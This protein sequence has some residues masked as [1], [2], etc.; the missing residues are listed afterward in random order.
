MHF[1]LAAASYNMFFKDCWEL[2]SDTELSFSS[3]VGGL[4]GNTG[5]AGRH[6]GLL[7]VPNPAVHERM[8]NRPPAA[9]PKRLTPSTMAKS[10]TSNR[11]T[12]LRYSLKCVAVS[13]N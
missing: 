13:K 10:S 9:L 6:A 7:G 4:I 2:K 3:A 11:Y 12:V 8:R 5:G 1:V